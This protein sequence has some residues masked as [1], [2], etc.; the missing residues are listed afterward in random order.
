MVSQRHI[1]DKFSDSYQLLYVT[2]QPQLE[3]PQSSANHHNAPN[4]TSL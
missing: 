1:L 3:P 2:I 4:F